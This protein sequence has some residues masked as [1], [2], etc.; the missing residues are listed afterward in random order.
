MNQP[1]EDAECTGPSSRN[2]PQGY[3]L[4]DE[5]YLMDQQPFLNAIRENPDDLGRYAIFADWLEKNGDPR[6]AFMNA[7]IRRLDKSATAAETEKLQE[8]EESLLVDHC[9]SWLDE[10]AVSLVDQNEEFDGVHTPSGYRFVGLRYIVWWGRGFLDTLE[11]YF[12]T[13]H[14]AEILKHSSH[15]GMLR[16]LIVKGVP[17]RED[18]EEFDD[19]ME[20]NSGLKWNGDVNPAFSILQGAVFENLRHFAVEDVTDDDSPLRRIMYPHDMYSAE[21]ANVPDDIDPETGVATPMP[22]DGCPASNIRAESLAGVIEHMPRLESLII[23][24][25]TLDHADLFRLEMPHLKYLTAKTEVESRLAEFPIR[26]LANNSSL[27]HLDSVSLFASDEDR[28][29][30][31]SSWQDEISSIHLE[32]LKAICRSRYLR[33]LANLSLYNSAFGDD[34]IVE[35]IESG[36]LRRLKSLNLTYGEITDDGAELLAT[37]DLSSLESLILDENRI[38]ENGIRAIQKTGVTLSAK[39]QRID[40]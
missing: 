21:Y 8:L 25:S 22:P 12:L 24:A 9:R 27:T 10:L 39:W 4:K 26:I 30:D 15:V 14:F 31:E 13:P 18:L 33:A 38:T 20:H 6:G 32:D 35:L 7:Q 29:D 40:E 34:G 11:V 2:E 5:A 37:T 28:W 23:F 3:M 17:E 16:Q 36:T 19:V 1:S